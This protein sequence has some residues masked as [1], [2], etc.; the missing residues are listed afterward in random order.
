MKQRQGGQKESN[1]AE[2]IEITE[3]LRAAQEEAV[4]KDR[5]WKQMTQRPSLEADDG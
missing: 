5:H 2:L 4:R 1:Q 3:E